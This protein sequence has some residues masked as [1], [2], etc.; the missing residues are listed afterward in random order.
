[1]LQRGHAFNTNCWVA[2]FIIFRSLV[3]D[4]HTR[5]GLD[6]PGH[7]WLEENRIHLMGPPQPFHNM[8]GCGVTVEEAIAA[9]VMVRPVRCCQLAQWEELA[10]RQG[11]SRRVS[12]GPLSSRRLLSLQEVFAMH[13]MCDYTPTRP[14]HLPMSKWASIERLAI[15]LEQHA[16]AEVEKLGRS[17]LKQIITAWFTDHPAFHGLPFSA[18]CKKLKD[19]SPLANPRNLVIKFSFEYTPRA[20][21]P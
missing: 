1:M 2:A 5:L 19:D 17:G 20:T 13:V 16:P 12:P 14:K 9:E 3:L 11:P 6:T 21:I 10:Q 4:T 7:T 15:P 18:W 8:L